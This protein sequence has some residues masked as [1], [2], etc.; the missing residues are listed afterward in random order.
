MADVFDPFGVRRTITFGGG[1]KAHLFHLA[2]LEQQGVGA[3]SRLPFS[4]KILIESVLRNCDDF[5]YSQDHVRKLA[6]WKVIEAEREETPYMPARV[7]LQDFTGVPAV[8]DLAAMRDAVKK[9]GGD[10]ARINPLIP[11][12]L[13]IDHSVQVDFFGTPDA[14]RKNEEV[15]FQ[16]NQERYEFLKWGQSAFRNFRVVPPSTGIVH[17]VNLEHLS[18]V[19][20]WNREKGTVYPD[21]CVGT[22]SHTPMVNGIGVV[23]WGVGG[24]E[25]EAVMLAQPIYMLVPDVVG[26]R[27]TG[28]MPEGTTATDLVL[29]I[30][31][32]C[33]KKGVVGKFVEFFGA[34]VSNLSVADRATI[35]NMAPEQGSTISFFP[36]DA[37]V[38]D[39][40]RLS[41]RPQE[42][43]DLTERYAKEQGLF[44]TDSTP[45]PIFTDVMELDLSTIEPALA[46]PK[47]PH[48]R[49][50][51]SKV[52]PTFTD[53]LTAPV[54]P[55]GFGLKPEE[56]SRTGE[57]KDNGH[58]NT[59]RHGSV[60][61]AAI[62]SCTNTSNP[63]VILGAA[64][65]AKK[66]VEKG[67]SV[68][69]YVK[70]SLAPGSTVVTEYLKKSGLQPYLDK[71]GFNIVGYGCTTC[72]G[73]SGPLPEPVAN[74]ITEGDL[75][76][77]AV[78]S[79]NRNF[80]GRVN[81]HTRAN[82]LASPPL[83]VAYA[84]AG[85]TAMDITKDPIGTGSDGKAVY[86]KDIWPTTEEVEK[87]VSANVSREQFESKY[88]D[89]WKGSKAW[90]DIQSVA[91]LQYAWKPAS[92]YIQNPP[93]FESLTKERGTI[94]PIS[95]A[96]VLAVFADSVTTDHISPAGNI[97]KDSPAGKYLLGK[98]VERTD[99]NSYGARRGN[100]H[101]MMRGTF[102]NIR[103]KNGLTP[104]I[105][106]NVTVYHPTG[107][108][109]SFFDAAERYHETKT[110]LVILAGKEYGSG[111]S[112]DWAAKGPALLGVKACI[113]ESYER[114][115]RSNLI[116]MGII[117]LQF[118]EGQNAQT[119]GLTGKE[120]F[121]F[122][123]NDT[124]QPRQ[125][126]QV[127][128]IGSDNTAKTFHAINRID[129]PVEI[130]YYRNGGILQTVLKK[131]G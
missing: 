119:L 108:Q 131:L 19:T 74:A 88:A 55:R 18:P 44:R 128:A 111:S 13:V 48:D 81:P 62:T 113:A 40:M 69:P 25:A 115:H 64:L 16:R 126:V 71:L 17:Q 100:H 32:M 4:I 68:K 78:L 31:E 83:V 112:R 104:G 67:L 53:V 84:L 95:G 9:I 5:A 127:R 15:E 35:G 54:G 114:I 63:S 39:Y 47:R 76:V 130:E 65:V 3:I 110:P 75:V 79:G 42:M 37:K 103:I 45:D 109:M 77:S 105:E 80:E 29:R 122:E 66:A 23:A 96:R 27:L 73:N 26:F 118:E 116:G 85:S 24:I 43:I 102:A 94:K 2:A 7:V 33:R 86:L 41:G 30:T 101:V 82:Y 129:T 56:L 21:S 93:F 20:F 11:C 121:E 70:T 51:L 6:N 50:P 124:L 60:V 14:L 125:R 59:I 107:E 46:G 106:G 98:G 92:T 99:W 87:C 61:L 34:G 58:S 72:I 12:D 91:G 52:G 10:P 90:Q 49:V 8:V 89:V 97:A 1:Q 123:L 22:D 28:R 36:I 120:Q 38:L 57:V 117:P